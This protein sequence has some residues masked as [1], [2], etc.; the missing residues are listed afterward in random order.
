MYTL[1]E[2]RD[3]VQ[4]DRRDAVTQAA[5]FTLR[6]CGDLA[7]VNARHPWPRA[8]VASVSNA[9]GWAVVVRLANG[10]RLY[11][12]AP[13]S[14]RR[15]QDQWSPRRTQALRFATKADA[16]RAAAEFAVNAHAKEY[17]VVAL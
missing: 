12:C 17:L 9:A 14:P 7:D 3:A 10:S 4:M 8:S 6:D 15:G 13:G 16:E 11:W 2:L 1:T 5:D